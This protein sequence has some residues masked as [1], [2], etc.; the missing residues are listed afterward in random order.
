ML[1]KESF[2]GLSKEKIENYRIMECEK[3]D[4]L[5]MVQWDECDRW[6]HFQCVGISSEIEDLDW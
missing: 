3:V 4:N 6:A 2:E 1:T 5:H